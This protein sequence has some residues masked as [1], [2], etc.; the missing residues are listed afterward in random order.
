MKRRILLPITV[1]ESTKLHF[2]E[3]GTEGAGHGGHTGLTVSE[4]LILR[5]TLTPGPIMSK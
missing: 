5:A 3:P 2:L 4:N 1:P